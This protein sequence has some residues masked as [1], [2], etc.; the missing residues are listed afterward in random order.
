M[1][2]TSLQ[3]PISLHKSILMLLA[4]HGLLILLRLLLDVE[5]FN[6][7]QHN[8]LAG[9]LKIALHHHLDKPMMQFSSQLISAGLET[10][11]NL[12]PTLSYT[13]E[14]ALAMLSPRERKCYTNSEANLNYLPFSDGY[15]SVFLK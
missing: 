4:M 9:G 14:N 12:K 8:K 10:H 1:V 13:T 6:Y 11:M 2:N 5:Q 15:R 7:E 3:A